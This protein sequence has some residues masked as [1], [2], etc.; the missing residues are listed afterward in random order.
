MAQNAPNCKD[1]QEIQFKLH[2]KFVAFRKCG[3]PRSNVNL[4]AV[5]SSRGL[6]FAGN[7]NAPELR[8]IIIKDVAAAKTCG[9]QP[10]ARL[11]PL[12]SIPNYMS[13]SAD[14]NLLAIN[15]TQPNGNSLLLIY[16][17]QSFMSPEPCVLYNIR[18]SPEDYVYAVQ[19]LWNP[20]LP[21]SL[22]VVLSNGGLAMYALK[23]GGNF[24]LHSLDKSQQIKCG[25]WSP[26]GKQL[27]LGFPGG[28]LQQF[29]PD[30]TPAKTLACPPNVHDAPFDTI[31][32]HW[33]STFQFAVV[34]LQHG[35]DCSPALYVINA[36]KAGAPTYT[37]Y[38]DICYSLNGPRNHQFNFTHVPQWNL[39]LVSSANG[40]EVG[41]LATTEAGDTPNWQQLTLL[42]EARIEMP[43]SEATQ[44]ETFPLGFA[45]DTSSTHQLS[46]NEQQLPSMPMVHVLGTDGT[47]LAFNFLN[48]Q[49]GAA[50]V[51]SPPPPLADTSGQFCALDALL[52]A[53]EQ[54]PAPP[55]AVAPPATVA[56]VEANTPALS[57]I[58]FAFT[59]NTVTSTPAP[60]KDK[61]P[62]LFAGFGNV[63]NKGPPAFGAPAAPLNFAAAP[64]KP[65]PAP[66]FGG[67][68]APNTAPPPTGS[69]FRL[70][71]PNNAPSFT[72]LAVD[73][74]APAPAPTAASL[75][76]TTTAAA[77]ATKANSNKPLYTVP[78]T[79][80]PVVTA[81]AAAPKPPA[82]GKNSE[83][84]AGEVDDVIVEIMNVQISAFS[85]QI[86]QQK[87]QTQ[88][89]LSQIE[90]PSTIKFYAKRL[91]DLQELNDQA[92]DVD[93][94]L[95]VQGLRHTLSEAYAMMAECRAKLE[96]Y[97][98]PDIT[99]LMTSTNFD[100]AGRRLLSRLQ[101]YVAAN[102]AQLQ[103]AQQQ[104]DA[105]WEQYQDV[106]RRSSKS[107]MHMPC[108]EGIYQRLTR[109]QN[110]T[111]DQRITQNNIKSRL[112]ERGLLQSALLNQ[113]SSRVRT[114]EAVDT[115][116]DSILSITLNQAVETNRAKL[117]QQK[118][119]C[120]RQLLQ[121]HNV[122]TISP[123][124]PDRVGLKSEVILET[125]LKAELKKKTAAAAAAASTA[126]PA[127][128]KPAV[129]HKATQAAAFASGAP[130]LAKPTASKP[131][132]TV[133][134][135]EKLHSLPVSV[136]AASAPAPVPANFSF[137]Q[138]SPFVK[139]TA[140]T[141]T[142]TTLSAGEVTKPTTS[143]FGGTSP[144]SFGGAKPMLPIGGL[145]A[146]PKPQTTATP[147]PNLFS[148]FG[149]V[150]V[151]SVK[152]KA[153][154]E[155]PKEASVKPV[156]AK[157]DMTAPV[158]PTAAEPARTAAP[159][160][161]AAPTA[162]AAKSEP[163]AKPFT[164]A[165]FGNNAGNTIGSNSSTFSFGGFGS[166]LGNS[167]TPFAPPAA[168]TTPAAAPPAVA[169]TTPATSSTDTVVSSSSTPAPTPTP[170]LTAA[171][172]PAAA[173][174][175]ASTSSVASTIST[176]SSAASVTSSS[177]PPV[178]NLFASINI[179]KP[180]TKD[181]TADAAPQQAN[182]FSGFGQSANSTFPALGAGGDGSKSLFGGGVSVSAADTTTSSSS[183]T[184]AT[185]ATTTTTATAATAAT[186]IAP[187]AT[188]ATPAA[189]VSAP[190][191]AAAASNA[192]STTNAAAA[193]G[194]K[195][196]F[197][198]AFS[199][200]NTA[201]G[202]PS[203]SLTATSSATSITSNTSGSIFGSANAFAPA[204]TASSPFGVAAAATAPSAAATPTG[205]IFGNVPKPEASVFGATNAAAPPSG[206]FAAAAAGNP[207]P[208]GSPA[209][210]P[211]A[212]PTAAA[213]SGGSIF[214][215][216]AALKP[217]GFGSP[218]A[219]GGSIFGGAANTAASPFGGGGS[220]IFGGG[221]SAQ[222]SP[223]AA[224]S[225]SVF[226]QSVFGQTS[227]SGS[228]GN[229]FGAS[230]PQVPAFGGGGGSIFGGSTS[231]SS[232][233]A[234]GGSIF[235]GGSSGGFG[236][237]AQ[238]NPTPG[239][240]GSAFAQSSGSVAQTGFGSPQQQ[241]Q[242]PAG[243]FGAKPV[244]GGS[245]AFG[246]SPTFGGAP[247]FGS[248]KGFGSFGASSG[249]VAPPAF[250]APAK[251]PEGNI[252]ETLGGTDTGGLSFGNLAQTGNTNNQ[253]ST[254][255]GSSFMT[256][257]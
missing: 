55:A 85:E 153:T 137:S 94:E 236:S 165:G 48:L 216:A 93:F 195:F 86:E 233:A 136:V 226:G 204:T 98:K 20:V 256:Y 83:F 34:F 12:P 121:Q 77:A 211:A 193:P 197:S 131:A 251:P 172:V 56:T 234:S 51:C 227:T 39:L 76:A 218:A 33:L 4:L 157:K 28:R 139:T 247:T 109:L 238:T 108:L 106:L 244:F 61:P 196:S 123:Q 141:V 71:A 13:C 46:I 180:Q 99:R 198:N 210:A 222:S 207:S 78:P 250:G 15:Y 16:A 2:D 257:R 91:E 79:F 225:A 219:A 95:D 30:L 14:G 65:L 81:P 255:G 62:S 237:F 29:K 190:T 155:P 168:A 118:L 182:I 8:V 44:D 221:N 189:T 143:F 21:N 57:D 40:V 104:I 159:A 126:P 241:T 19:L 205:N 3:E 70:P 72:N 152:P 100:A 171:A 170:S 130:Q 208:F 254:F 122:H 64:A 50:S 35:E 230:Q 134:A 23:D 84:S 101:S 202:T 89:L 124:R 18:M 75:P 203:G 224:P 88:A 116:A 53:E 68:G 164:F 158:E 213:S 154:S 74:P 43:L 243:A 119:Q 183:N 146:A 22:A 129:A 252:F 214:G 145:N 166:S 114:N 242:S 140:S 138:S 24:E 127:S 27:V 184:S 229:L 17:V 169:T 186:T 150:G 69:M 200:L 161:T 135:I 113:E 209:A 223:A 173:S 174:D 49:P 178:D 245:P 132:A 73:K 6:L 191:F 246:A 7:P 103:L 179:C 47:L 25:C 37:N 175:T 45:Y 1:T 125:K 148:G 163:A 59:P 133:A 102:E 111:S 42:D 235:G 105:Q 201:G 38:Y 32:V 176:T 194:S 97:R 215:Q 107:K 120:I 220:S 217:S 239:A 31:A 9:K 228:G 206:L 11:V 112:K 82:A 80:T 167:A 248:P 160:S 52:G 231:T 149:N 142:T 36:P 156:E 5:S 41:V 110:M 87:Q 10:L 58:S 128:A 147:A 26:K 240:F 144:F 232:P 192:V 177:A 63:S 67:F 212:P 117:S 92:N 199:S 96:V 54:S 249:V 162:T 66:S 185:T 181:S 151:D 90:S 188:V 115:L 60:I 253:K 187:A